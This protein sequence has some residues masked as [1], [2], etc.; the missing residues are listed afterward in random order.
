MSNEIWK[1]IPN[2]EGFYEVSSFGR[3]KVLRRKVRHYKGGHCVLKEQILK[4]VKRGNYLKVDIRKDGKAKTFN[5]HQLVAMAFL[6]HFPSRKIVVDHKDNDASNNNLENLQIITARDNSSKD[7]KRISNHVGVYWYKRTSKWRAQISINGKKLGLGYFVS[8]S[9][10]ANAYQ[11][12][13]KE[14][15]KLG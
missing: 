7:R 10:A 4:P 6:G 11:N 9:E 5:I 12:K 14:L 15:K 3:V 1:P 2:Y 8:E 13:L